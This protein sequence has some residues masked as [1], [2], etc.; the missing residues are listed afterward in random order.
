MFSENSEGET[1][2]Y[3]EFLA[4]CLVKDT[5]LNFFFPFFLLVWVAGNQEAK[6]WIFWAHQ[7]PW[8]TRKATAGSKG[9]R[10]KRNGE[11]N[12]AVGTRY[13]RLANSLKQQH[14]Q[15]EWRKILWCFARKSE[16]QRP[17]RDQLT[18]WLR[19]GGK[20]CV[21]VK[22]CSFSRRKDFS[23]FIVL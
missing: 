19:G 4:L 13:P 20:K 2:N 12:E 7:T 23:L 22:G 17:A 6:S 14:K 5:F 18:D 11:T 10:Q 21:C 1:I 9:G 8:V 3:L 15:E 16:K